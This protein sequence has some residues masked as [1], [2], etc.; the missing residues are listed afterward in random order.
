[1]NLKAIAT[2]FSKDDTSLPNVDIKGFC[3]DSRK[4]NPGELFIALKGE[5]DDGHLFVA[6]AQDKGAI[7]A[8][9]QHSTPDLLPQIEVTDTLQALAHIACTHRQEIHCPV[10][11]LT[12]SNGKTSVKEMVACILPKPSW[13]TQGNLN[14][15]IGAPL[16]VLGLNKEHQYAVFELGANHAGEIA[17]TAAIVR[18]QVALIN[19]I[20]PAHVE[21][22]GSIDGVAQAKGEI[23]A[24]LSPSGT[25]IVNE[26]DAYNHFW[27]EVIGG[28]KTIRFSLHTRADVCVHNQN[29]EMLA[30]GCGAFTLELP[31][32][33]HLDI[34]LRVPGLHNVANALAAASCCYAVGINAQKIQ[35]GLNQYSGV[36]GRLSFLEGKKRHNRH[37]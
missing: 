1:M 10:I 14:N 34:R 24:A 9:V 18:P 29:L 13:A 31:G 12:G 25:A 17:Y 2:L 26:D 37:R 28:R 16:S 33:I 4:L 5:Q 15:H 7:A 30:N 21:G 6:H 35:E 23:Y 20:G 27:D 19:N 36:S 22:F 11:A 32:S 3:I 8:L